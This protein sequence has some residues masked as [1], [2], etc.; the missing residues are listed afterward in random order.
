MHGLVPL[1]YRHL[2]AVA[3]D[4]ED[5]PIA[6]L[7]QESLENCQ[8]V[9]H[10]LNRLSELLAVFKAEHIPVL[11]FKGPLIAELAYGEN[12]LRQA[13]DLDLLIAVEN[14][15]Q[16][17]SALERLGYR[18]GPS[19]T[20]RQQKAHLAFHC[21]IQ[22]QRDNGF[23]VVDL[24]WSLSPKAFPFALHTE[25][26]L[27]R[28]RETMIAGQPVYTFAPEDLILFQCMHGAKHYWSKL[29]W[30]GSLAEIIRAQGEIDWPTVIE[31]GR[32]ARAVKI[33][34]L[35]LYL[36]M[37][38]GEVLIP[39]GVFQALDPHRVIKKIANNAL[40]SVFIPLDV[41][42]KSLRAVGK[43]FGIMDRKRDALAS[44]VR[45]IFVPTL[46]DWQT[47]SL[48]AF[49]HPLYYALRPPRLIKAY[50]ESVVRRT[51]DPAQPLTASLPRT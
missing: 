51:H 13:G 35:G 44:L 21:E 3:A 25:D 9:L 34:A 2:S 1:L 43:N 14:F 20:K 41:E 46:S 12:S 23:T 45:A 37:E 28:A 36:A 40:E 26:V 49:L 11:L 7:R 31:R 27:K 47:I 39:E 29:E 6:A 50:A 32:I 4:Y 48:P 18:M 10:L 17:R 30:I 15:D 42:H 22:F 5:I 8:S 24:H 38:L 19:L 16:A 33:V